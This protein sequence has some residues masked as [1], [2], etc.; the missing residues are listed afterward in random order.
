MPRFGIPG[1]T[2]YLCL[3][4]ACILLAAFLSA[5]AGGGTDATTDDRLLTLEAQVHLQEELLEALQEENGTLRTELLAVQEENAALKEEMAMLRR[6]Q[7]EYVQ[8]REASEPA[9]EHEEDVADFEEDLARTGERLD[10]LG[11]R[12]EDLERV[13]AQVEWFLPSMRSWFETVEN[14]LTALE[15][16]E[17][18]RTARL[19]ETGGGK[20]QVVNFGAAY[21]G[22]RSAVLVLPSPLPEDE[23]PLIVSLHGFGGDP[24]TQALYLPMHHRVNSG[25]FALLIPEGSIGPEGNRFWNATDWCCGPEGTTVDDV[26][27][28][29]ALVDEA[30]GEF[31]M[32]PVYLFGHSNG[33]F[34]SYRMACEG[35]SGLRAVASLAGTG[36]RDDSDCNEPSPLSVLHI[37][38]TEDATVRFQGRDEDADANEGRGLANYAGAWETIKLW[39]ARAGCV[40]PDQPEPHASLD[41]D[42]FVPGA[43]TS[44]YRLESACGEGSSIELWVG[45]GSG[46]IPGYGE[47]FTDALL[48]W[49]LA[50]R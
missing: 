45:E 4:A 34:M 1:T 44:A 2:R 29:T 47:A 41:L 9:G 37:H 11:E 23:I 27:A 38:G 6:E 49:L 5:C 7:S 8:A 40:W 10:D 21:G 46:H 17:I 18:E 39:S 26:A 19:A 36:D 43:E 13:A 33:G 14:R 24:F 50:Q 20:A 48:N 35:L 3:L 25:R 12:L 32:G 42:A 22:E 16:S 31:N 30:G 15:G 28:L